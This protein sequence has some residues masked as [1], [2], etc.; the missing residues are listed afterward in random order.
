[1]IDT[2]PLVRWDYAARSWIVAHRYAAVDVAMWTLSA[3]G[4]GGIVWLVLGVV[5]TVLRRLPLRALVQLALAIALATLVER[6]SVARTPPRQ[7]SVIRRAKTQKAA[8][9]KPY[10]GLGRGSAP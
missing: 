3:V 1:M 6:S 4:R 8:A 2:T 5:L 10:K 7:P 9:A